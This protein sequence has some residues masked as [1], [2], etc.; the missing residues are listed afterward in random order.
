MAADKRWAAHADLRA[1]GR[2]EVDR[3]EP[4]T[5][6]ALLSMM[7]NG[8]ALV[9]FDFPIGVPAAYAARAG[10]RSFNELLA[11]LG[12][13]AWSSFF[14]VARTRAEISLQ[15]PFYPNA[16][17]GTKRE[18]LLEALGLRSANELFRRCDIAKGRR[19]CPLF[20][21][22]GGNQVGKAA[23]SGWREVL[24][25]ARASGVANLW[26][27]DGTLD[28]L[29]ARGRTV[30][31][32]TYPGDVYS[33]VGASLPKTP[34]GYGK[35]SQASRAASARGI[36]EWA[37]RAD[38]ELSAE[39]DR[40]LRDGFGSS[41]SGE[42]RFDAFVGLLGMCAVVQGAREV[43]APASD[44]VREIEGWILGRAAS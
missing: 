5:P 7:S 19:A 6:A 32:E 18:H 27:F 1:D 38:I 14:D 42:D 26:P 16:A 21:T 34:S 25:P 12:N 4:I 20:W 10:V 35:R 2:Y 23:L 9:G 40:E 24:Q 17:G 28:E 44:D 8:A 31:V 30:I 33:Y 29:L 15:R 41:K 22:L 11:L 3:P 39:L 36:A 43:G 37:R 13:G